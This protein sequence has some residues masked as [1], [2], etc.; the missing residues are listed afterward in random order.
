M[1][2]SQG[3]LKPLPAGMSLPKK[4]SPVVEVGDD[5]VQVVDELEA[6]GGVAGRVGPHQRDAQRLVGGRRREGDEAGM[7]LAGRQRVSWVLVEDLHGRGGLDE[8]VGEADGQAVGEVDQA[9][10]LG[11]SGVAG[12]GMR[13]AW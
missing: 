11:V 5:E 10:A 2:V 7:A 6:G 3:W 9:P 12:P 1:L 8:G 13:R 4:T